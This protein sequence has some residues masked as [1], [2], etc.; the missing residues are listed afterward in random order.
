MTD[1]TRLSLRPTRR[2]RPLLLAVAAILAVA[3]AGCGSGQ[4]LSSIGVYLCSKNAKNG[5][6]P[7][8]THT[9]HSFAKQDF[10]VNA[11]SGFGVSTLGVVVDRQGTNGSYAH[12]DSTQQPVDPSTAYAYGPAFLWGQRMP[13]PPGKYSITVTDG[14]ETLGTWDFTV[15][16]SAIP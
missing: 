10:V 13:W 1:L 11:P 12:Y 7:A 9:L 4:N 15:T 5:V 6:C 8:S 3:A 16:K 14:S 2:A